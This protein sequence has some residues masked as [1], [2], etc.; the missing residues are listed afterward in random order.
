MLMKD[1]FIASFLGM[2]IDKRMGISLVSI[3]YNQQQHYIEMIA[4][5]KGLEYGVK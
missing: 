2:R 5:V 1:E 4:I 3:R